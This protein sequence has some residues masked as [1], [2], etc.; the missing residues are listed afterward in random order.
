MA[1][2]SATSLRD[3]ATE[4]LGSDRY[5]PFLARV[6]WELV[7]ANRGLYPEPETVAYR[8]L[9]A[10]ICVNEILHSL[11]SQYLSD[12]GDGRGGYSDRALIDDVLGKSRLWRCEETCSEAMRG[13]IEQTEHW[14][15]T[16]RANGVTDLPDAALAVLA[17]DQRGR[18]LAQLILRLLG[19][20]LSVPTPSDPNLTP[21]IAG[22]R[23]R[24]ELLSLVARALLGGAGM[25]EPIRDAP[26]FVETLIGTANSGRCGGDLR[27]AF[28]RAL[29]TATVSV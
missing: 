5:A 19:A 1:S 20:A 11:T 2:G 28:E 29:A 14:S 21:H 8:Q 18:F 6:A 10:M 7:V 24:Y 9:G 22:F 23:C 3:R 17:S 16:G 25:D 27:H 15:Q 26:R 13:A 4:A 12:F